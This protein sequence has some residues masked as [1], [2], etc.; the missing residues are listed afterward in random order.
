[1][2]RRHEHLSACFT[3]VLSTL[4]LGLVVAVA[5]ACA[6]PAPQVAAT[7]RPLGSEYPVYA[8]TGGRDAARTST[9]RTNPTR[10]L[11]LRDSLA[12]ALLENPTLAAYSW[13]TRVREAEALQ[14]G[15]LPNPE[16][17][18]EGEDFA[19][20]GSFTGYDGAQTTIFL[21][22]LIELGGK[23]SK[24][25]RVATLER[26]LASWDYEVKRLDVFTE[27]AVA[28]VGVLQAQNEVALA[29][30][31]LA[32]AGESIQAVSKQ[33]RAGATS[34]VEETRAR[35]NV[36]SAR[37]ELR[38][39]RAALQTARTRLSSAWG[40]DSARFGLVL[41]D[42]RGV[43]APPPIDSIRDKLEQNPDVARWVAEL[44]HRD[45]AI[46]LQDA[47]A[48]PDVT[49]GAGVRRLEQDNDTAFV[50]GVTVPLPV[51]DR[52]QGGRQ[53]ARHGLAK[54]RYEQRAAFVR[55]ASALEIALE[56]LQSSFDQIEA[57]RSD[58]LPQ[59]VLAYEGVRRGYQRGLFRYIEVLDAQRTLF[60]LRGRELSALGDYHRTVAEAERLI[61]EPLFETRAR[62][63]AS[64]SINP[65][66]NEESKR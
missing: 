16:L 14:A 59:A 47:G 34:S 10:D 18:V 32:I 49:A 58:V 38:A 65:R 4:L 3:H 25:R 44:A 31:V 8:A 17:T 5:L 7:P 42:L 15:L 23:R 21:G 24:R 33:V 66:T 28:F 50:F 22:Q 64:T 13:E 48:I 60:E 20:T 39:A 40:D 27:V 41:G 55:A 54:A 51:F 62:P 9:T 52:N 6:A 56:N 12:L 63:T 35:V 45:A 19:G 57:L 11:T 43:E 29:E 37:V 2:I 53:A 26:D 1:M 36:A 30:E 61:G 46:A